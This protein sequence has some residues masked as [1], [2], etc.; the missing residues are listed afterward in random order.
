M[1]RTCFQHTLNIET[2]FQGGNGLIQKGGRVLTDLQD[3]VIDLADVWRADPAA[4]VFSAAVAFTDAAKI[5]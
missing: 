5:C 2:V 3:Q 1:M 4:V